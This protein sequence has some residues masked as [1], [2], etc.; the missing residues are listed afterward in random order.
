MQI[1]IEYLCVTHGINVSN[2]LMPFSILIM[3]D[4]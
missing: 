1:L 2:I 4:L 3:H